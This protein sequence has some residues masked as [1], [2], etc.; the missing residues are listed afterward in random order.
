[1][2]PECEEVYGENCAKCAPGYVIGDGEKNEDGI[3]LKVCKA[4][5]N[6]VPHCLE[7]ESDGLCSQCESGF[8][9]HDDVVTFKRAPENQKQCNPWPN[10][11]PKCKTHFKDNLNNIRCLE[12]EPGFMLSEN[13]D[14]CFEH[15]DENCLIASNIGCDQCLSGYGLSDSP[16]NF[17]PPHLNNYSIGQN[18]L[19]A[20]VNNR[21]RADL[22]HC[23]PEIS[24]CVRY[25]TISSF[26]TKQ[27]TGSSGE[28]EF[29]DDVDTETEI[30]NTDMDRKLLLT[31]AK[32]RELLEIKFGD[33]EQNKW[34]IGVSKSHKH[35]MDNGVPQTELDDKKETVKEQG[36][37]DVI[38]NDEGEIV[39]CGRCARGYYLYQVEPFKFECIEA[40]YIEHCEEYLDRTTCYLCE[41]HFYLKDGKC[42]S[43]E[44]K[45][46]VDHCQYYKEDQTCLMC[47]NEFALLQ[48]I[49]TPQDLY[50]DEKFHEDHPYMKNKGIEAQP[51][52]SN[53]KITS[54]EK[55]ETINV[56]GKKYEKVQQMS[57]TQLMTHVTLQEYIQGKKTMDDVA[58]QKIKDLGIH[59]DLSTLHLN[60]DGEN[61]KTQVFEREKLSEED[62]MKRSQEL[63][64]N[65]EKAKQNET[66]TDDDLKHIVTQEMSDDMQYIEKQII[67][68]DSHH[69]DE[70]IEKS[71]IVEKG[72]D[73]ISQDK[74]SEIMD[75]E[76]KLSSKEKTEEDVVVLT[77]T[78][79]DEDR[80]RARKLLDLFNIFSFGKKKKK[81][82][83]G[84]WSLQ[85]KRKMLRKLG[86]GRILEKKEV[87]ISDTKTTRKLDDSTTSNHMANVDGSHSYEV[88]QSH[89]V[90]VDQSHTINMDNESVNINDHHSEETMSVQHDIHNTSGSINQHLTN[91]SHNNMTVHDASTQFDSIVEN[92]STRSI[93]DNLKI[94]NDNGVVVLNESESESIY[95]ATPKTDHGSS[96]N[97]SESNTSHLQTSGHSGHS[98][99]SNDP[100]NSST[101]DYNSH[102]LE[103]E[104]SEKVRTPVNDSISNFSDAYSMG[105]ES[106]R[107]R[108]VHDSKHIIME[109]PEDL[110]NREIEKDKQ[111]LDRLFDHEA[112]HDYIDPD[113]ISNKDQKMKLIHNIINNSTTDLKNPNEDIVS[114]QNKP[115]L[116]NL[117]SSNDSNLQN[118]GLLK[119][120]N[121][122][123][124]GINTPDQKTQTPINANAISNINVKPTQPE[125]TQQTQN[126]LIPKE[127]EKDKASVQPNKNKSNVSEASMPEKQKE[128]QVQATDDNEAHILPEVRKVMVKRSLCVISN[129]IANCAVHF[130]G[131]CI[132]CESDYH[133][134]NNICKPLGE[135]NK[136]MFCQAYNQHQNCVKCRSGFVLVSGKCLK[137]KQVINC[138]NQVY[139]P[140]GKCLICKHG[141]IFD[142]EENKCMSREQIYF[143]EKAREENLTEEEIAHQNVNSSDGE[144]IGFDRHCLLVRNNSS[145]TC[146]MCRP[147]YY[148]DKQGNCFFSE[149]GYKKKWVF[150]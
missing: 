121:L 48:M 71:T 100:H 73:I 7:Y 49:D 22:I 60:F 34:I 56:G 129:P 134:I 128:I 53:V 17:V 74:D 131:D 126:S 50:V 142:K 103:S 122:D 3:P 83:K 75:D 138:R 120:I 36:A 52:K 115:N 11:I 140:N 132:E 28:E 107:L 135:E 19:H 68:E 78:N 133:L 111:I 110:K 98:N 5:T 24:H 113:A 136:V 102:D 93:P 47:E 38:F 108:R 30:D 82:S 130:R 58:E 64:K 147:G 35:L 69:S 92:K 16:M 106:E 125:S 18:I 76:S 33:D 44:A 37:S 32:T 55:G 97:M 104:H 96:P 90:D 62:E 84:A 41:K 150:W 4:I 149:G 15:R 59:Y 70:D 137:F 127:N 94:Q 144:D 119:G 123:G 95:T 114:S 13:M 124:T 105:S 42:V 51:H 46:F 14:H 72:D 20:M 31:K 101:K 112:D 145:K 66:D 29:I 23:M 8:F 80:H 148:M 21:K 85:G 9:L 54:K 117:P 45:N 143:R 141:Y 63:R 118:S 57:I 88:H 146:F 89:S 43:I 81:N 99:H 77:D 139:Y 65:I 27:I 25:I 79:K 91:V 39:T 10:D 26:D 12:C 86:K 6:S 109:T 116:A 1:L 2:F 40:N 87:N 61:V 67:T